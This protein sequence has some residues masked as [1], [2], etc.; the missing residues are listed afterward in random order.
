MEPEIWNNN[1]T[2]DNAYTNLRVSSI[3]A[4]RVIANTLSDG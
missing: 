1:V 2:L 3:Y 4:E